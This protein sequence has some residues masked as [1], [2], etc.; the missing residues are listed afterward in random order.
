MQY[1]VFIPLR[2][3]DM[4]SLAERQAME[5]TQVSHKNKPDKQKCALV[6]L[7]V[8]VDAADSESP[9]WLH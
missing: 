5:V 3:S 8:R 2:V 4:L 1:Y 6:M 7:A 9:I